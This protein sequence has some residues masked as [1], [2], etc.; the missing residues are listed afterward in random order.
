MTSLENGIL[1]GGTTL[2]AMLDRTKH[3]SLEELEA[4]VAFYKSPL[5]HK[6]VT[7]LPEVVR[8]CMAAGQAWGEQLGKRAYDRAQAYKSRPSA[9]S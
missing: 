4:L 6:V 8:E 5:G 9:K 1:G 2:R 3:F 7:T